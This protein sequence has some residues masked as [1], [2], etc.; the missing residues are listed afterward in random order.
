[1]RMTNLH[2]SLKWLWIAGIVTWAATVSILLWRLANA[3][4]FAQSSFMSSRLMLVS[5]FGV[6]W[7]VAPAMWRARHK[8]MG[9]GEI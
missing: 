1:M 8:R 4:T 6:F 5:L 9:K 2:L 3:E 7:G